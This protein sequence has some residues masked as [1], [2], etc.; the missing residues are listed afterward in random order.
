MKLQSRICKPLSAQQKLGFKKIRY[1]C[2]EA[3]RQHLKHVWVDTCCI[4]K[5]S[6]AE[7]SEAINSM[8][9][10]Y[11]KSEICFVYLS[12]VISGPQ[13]EFSHE[14]FKVSQLLTPIRMRF[15]SY[16]WRSLGTKV[17][18]VDLISTVTG[19]EREASIA[20]KMSWASKRTTTRQ[21]DIA[22]CLLGILKSTC[23]SSMIDLEKQIGWL[24]FSHELDA[25]QVI[26]TGCTTVVKKS[27]ET[28]KLFTASSTSLPTFTQDS[29][30]MSSTWR[31]TLHSAKM[32][33]AFLPPISW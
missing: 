20:K 12:D 30:P 27:S 8:F 10:W 3:L 26:G 25:W 9:R 22:Y 14:A 24:H 6:S 16:D 7:L 28:N 18:L 32:L 33:L 1:T 21:E 17:D 29:E 23:H 5:T 4:D 2:D 31:C 19:I 11:E 13:L 15:F